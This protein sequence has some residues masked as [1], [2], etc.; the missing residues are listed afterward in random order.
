[1]AAL[2]YAVQEASKAIM[3][4]Y[5]TEDFQVKY[6]DDKS[7]LTLAD[8]KAN[9]II[10]MILEEYH[11]DIPILSEES[12]E[13][14]YE[15]RKEW[16]E[17]F[18]VDPVDGTK[19]FIK[20]N[21]QF[22]VNIGWIKDGQPFAGVVG[23]PAQGKIYWAERCKGAWL[24]DQ[25]DGSITPISVSEHRQVPVVLSSLSHM[26]EATEKFVNEHWPDHTLE[27]YGSSLKFL[28]IAEGKADVYARLVPC[29]EWDT[30]A[31]HAILE[32]AGGSIR[33]LD[34]NPIT[35]NKEDLHQ[36]FFVASN[37]KRYESI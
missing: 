14:P 24:I 11:P 8:I 27:R 2:I 15:E 23:I 19:E 32:E 31:S 35:Y 12:K 13:I 28:Q 5:G 33:D 3:E 20:R 16:D 1:M 29:M 22:T 36:P 21:G 25:K 18:L 34:D 10:T 30:A 37:T 7:P 26:N 17:F 6:K 9:E 4:I